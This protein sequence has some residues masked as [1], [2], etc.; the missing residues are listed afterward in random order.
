MY[1]DIYGEIDSWKK[2]FS[3][4]NAVTVMCVHLP[5]VV[6]FVYTKVRSLEIT[7]INYYMVL[8]FPLMSICYT[9]FHMFRGAHETIFLVSGRTIVFAGFISLSTDFVLRV[10]S[11][12]GLLSYL[13][14]AAR[15]ID[16]SFGCIEEMIAH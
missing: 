5:L 3:L 10:G 2:E 14:R 16:Q 13:L 7:K 8:I 11:V 6:L 12:V 9:I 1:E 15:C 4:Q